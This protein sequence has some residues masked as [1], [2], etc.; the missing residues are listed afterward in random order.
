MIKRFAEKDSTLLFIICNF[1]K[2]Y[3]GLVVVVCVAG[4]GLELDLCAGADALELA[5]ALLDED[6]SGALFRSSVRRSLLLL[7]AAEL[8]EDE[9]NDETLELEVELLSRS[10]D[11]SSV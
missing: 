3:E 8:E 10:S 6:S 1:Y 4:V 7:E 2:S 9:D 11:V 5:G